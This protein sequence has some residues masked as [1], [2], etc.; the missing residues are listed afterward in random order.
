VLGY[1][2]VPSPR[3]T[4][5]SEIP[6]IGEVGWCRTCKVFLLFWYLQVPEYPNTFAHIKQKYQNGNVES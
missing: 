6:V 4:P 2:P 1:L 5:T 3:F